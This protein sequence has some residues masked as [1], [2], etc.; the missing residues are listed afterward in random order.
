MIIFEAY[1]TTAADVYTQVCAG[2]CCILVGCSLMVSNRGCSIFYGVNQSQQVACF[3]KS[4]TDKR[5]SPEQI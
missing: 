2:G 5:K 1:V 4:I 3:I